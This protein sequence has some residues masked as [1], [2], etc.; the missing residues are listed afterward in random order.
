MQLLAVYT[1]HSTVRLVGLLQ[2]LK[3]EKFS[4]SS[5]EQM[6]PDEARRRL[7]E[8]GVM[9]CMDVPQGGPNDV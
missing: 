2:L 1:T 3:L 9:L 5:L 6:E 8:G 4:P 7:L